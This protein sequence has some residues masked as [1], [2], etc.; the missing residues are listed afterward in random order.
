MDENTHKKLFAKINYNLDPSVRWSVD[1]APWKSVIESTYDKRFSQLIQGGVTVKSVAQLDD[2]TRA[3]GGSGSSGSKSRSS[4]KTV[5][6]VSNEWVPFS[7]MKP[8]SEE[9]WGHQT[10]WV[11]QE[12]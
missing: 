9:H 12:A 6:V 4:L 8:C 11:L 7:G 5:H 2:P 3:L 1:Q 10:D